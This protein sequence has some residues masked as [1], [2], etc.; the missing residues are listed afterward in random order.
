[1][2]TELTQEAEPP[3]AEEAARMTHCWPDFLHTPIQTMDE[4]NEVSAAVD[5]L[6]I[7]ANKKWIAGRVATLLSQYFA[8]SVPVEMM[9]AIA[10]DWNEELRKFPSWSIQKACRWWMSA[11]NDKRRQKPLPG[12]IAARCKTELGVVQVGDLALRR[13]YAGVEPIKQAKPEKPC[14]KEAAA[15]IMAKAGFAAKS[16]GGNK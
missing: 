12:D 13:F 14:S 5:R 3:T 7:P 11:E 1:M 10:D 15:E 8:S 4:A 6:T 16:F 2:T 9:T